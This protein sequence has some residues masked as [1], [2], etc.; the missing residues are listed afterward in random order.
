[1][2]RL[3]FVTLC[4]TETRWSA[5]SD[6]LAMSLF[7]IHT[8]L[9][10]QKIGSTQQFKKEKEKNNNNTDKMTITV[11]NVG[12]LQRRQLFVGIDCKQ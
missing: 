8:A 4:Y 10:H 7:S 12:S 2:G 1:M 6:R 9:F 11:T 3:Y 5:L